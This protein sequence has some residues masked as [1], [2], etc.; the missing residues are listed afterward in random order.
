[1]HDIQSSSKIDDLSY[2]F[3]GLGRMGFHMAEH[4]IKQHPSSPNCNF[5]LYVYDINQQS[6]INFSNHINDKYKTSTVTVYSCSTLKDIAENCSIIFTMVPKPEHVLEVYDLI[7][8]DIKQNDD[9]DSQLKRIWN[10]QKDSELPFSRIFIDSSTVDP[11]TSKKLFSKVANIKQLNATFIDAPVSGGVRGAELG[12][13]TFMLGASDVITQNENLKSNIEPIFKNS[14]G[15]LGMG[16]S[17][18]WCGNTGTGAFAKLCNNYVLAVT[19]LATCEAYALAHKAGIKDEVFHEI[20]NTS[21]AQS[22]TTT[23]NTPVPN[24]NKN[25]PACRDYEN[26]FAISLV[27][28]DVGLALKEFENATKDHGDDKLLL[29]ALTY[30]I[31]D[32]LDQLE[33]EKLSQKDLG[34]YYKHILSNNFDI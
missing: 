34:V 20:A 23:V 13:L 25:S 8:S 7:I 11:T 4:I 21:S 3:I 24:I 26:G 33:D 2:G 22:W 10:F 9:T 16:K 31:Y 6:A 5:K 29:P 28:K 18:V 17:V 15:S 19:N 30:D 27:K 32:K 12:S 14:D 1:M